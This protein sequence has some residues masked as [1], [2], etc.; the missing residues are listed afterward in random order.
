M[1][2]LSVVKV[3]CIF[4]NFSE[5]SNRKQNRS[6]NMFLPDDMNFNRFIQIKVAK[7]EP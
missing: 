1:M 2:Y 5:F 4:I 6:I 7:D 3:Y